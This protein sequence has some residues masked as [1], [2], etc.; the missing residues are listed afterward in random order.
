MKID[1][2][3]KLVQIIPS[4]EKK[5]IPTNQATNVDHNVN[6]YFVKQYI[7]KSGKFFL[8]FENNSK[9]FTSQ[10][11]VKFYNLSHPNKQKLAL[12]LYQVNDGI[13]LML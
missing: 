2:I 5:K 8:N 7:A 10:N 12:K 6:P 11:V 3:T 1:Y 13:T 9:Q 4:K